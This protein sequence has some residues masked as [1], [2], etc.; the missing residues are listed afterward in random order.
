MRIPINEFKEQEISIQDPI[1]QAL[2]QWIQ[3]D[4]KVLWMFVIDGEFWKKDD[5]PTRIETEDNGY[6]EGVLS[7]LAY[8]ILKLD[9]EFTFQDILKFHSIA[10]S[11]LKNKQED[12]VIGEVRKSGSKVMMAYG[13]ASEAG[14]E[15][16]YADDNPIHGLLAEDIEAASAVKAFNKKFLPK[17]NAMMDRGKQFTD[18]EL[19]ELTRVEY[20]KH[21]EERMITDCSLAPPNGFGP[22]TEQGRITG[23]WLASQMEKD[24]LISKSSPKDSIADVLKRAKLAVKQGL[25]ILFFPPNPYTTTDR[26]LFSSHLQYLISDALKRYY[27]AIGKAKNLDDKLVA[28]S[29][30]IKHCAWTHPFIDGNNRV[31]VNVLLPLLCLQLGILPG[32]LYKPNIFEGMAI[33]EICGYLR[34]AFAESRILLKDPNVTIF[35]YSNSNLSPKI[36]EKFQDAAQKLLNNSKLMLERLK[37]Q[38]EDKLAEI[39]TQ[40]KQQMAVAE[41]TGS[42]SADSGI[43]L[44]KA[45]QDPKVTSAQFQA[46]VERA[47]IDGKINEKGKKIPV[48]ALHLAA[49]KGDLHKMKILIEAGADPTVIDE[50]TAARLV[51]TATNRNIV[52]GREVKNAGKCGDK[53]KELL[54]AVCNS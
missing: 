49:K 21:I 20:E 12:L 42:G 10:L 48:T 24:S 33:S 50:T 27:Q 39:Q 25:G 2:E 35:D 3:F 23:D 5:G 17:I 16:I 9:Q 11:A 22:K 38:K 36:L 1:I 37:K 6:V 8:G 31:F 43:E 47:K 4:T 45:V 41:P 51:S 53:V 30:L 15:M 18:K 28:L 40:L 46:I 54:A 44:R 34:D 14:I 26:S 19:K 29:Y 52:F 32:I 7:A 13:C